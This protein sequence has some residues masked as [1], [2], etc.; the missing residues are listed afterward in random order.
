MPL[1]VEPSKPRLCHNQRFLNLLIKDLPFM[2][3]TLK[4]IHRIIQKNL[5]MATCDEKYGYYHLKL[6]ESFCLYF[7]A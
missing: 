3:D 7:G 2:L 5:L 4:D 6:T 1:T